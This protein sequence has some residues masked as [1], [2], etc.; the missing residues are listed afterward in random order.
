[1]I[2][3]FIKSLS[4]KGFRSTFKLILFKIR[5]KF[6]TV[7]KTTVAQNITLNDWLSYY[8]NRKEKKIYLSNNH[9]LM[10]Y[11]K[12]SILI[13]TYNNLTFNQLCLQSIYCNTTYPNFEIIV[14]DNASS[15]E[16]PAW[17]KIYN[18]NHEN[19]KVIFNSENIGFA[20]GNNQVA[21]EAT[22]EYLIFLNN[23]TVVT[24][25]WIEKLLS[26]MKND[27]LLGL[28]GPVTNSTGNEARITTSYKSPE[29]MEL[30]A[31]E[32]S[33]K[34]AGINFDIRMLAMFCTMTR[35]DQFEVI[36]GLDE[37]FRMGMFEDDDLAVRYHKAGLKVICA[38]DIFIHHFQSASFEKLDK[39]YYNQIFSENRRKYE[40]KW[41]HEWEPY[42]FRQNSINKKG[43]RNI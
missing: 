26:H 33:K 25:G 18:K 23:D 42:Q 5:T 16:T 7:S 19:L 21:S 31:S 30:F 11:P 3:R 22:G 43:T 29:E 40:K 37:R 12:V 4:E 10:D 20:A 24:E 39:D 27:P 14:V 2:F 8:L 34:M 9:N 15:D 32:R 13:L 35:K 28:V 1:M 38:E 36:G 17:L 6:L 41:G